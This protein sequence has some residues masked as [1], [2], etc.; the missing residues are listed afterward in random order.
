MDEISIPIMLVSLYVLTPYLIQIRIFN[1]KNLN[2]SRVLNCHL[3][4][5]IFQMKAITF[6]HLG[7]IEKA[8][9]FSVDVQMSL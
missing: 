5:L 9:T 7:T 6:Y 3:L 4:Y 8:A 2:V 1:L